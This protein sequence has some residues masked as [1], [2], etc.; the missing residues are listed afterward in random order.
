[1]D[2]AFGDGKGEILENRFVVDIDVKVFDFELIHEMD[3]FALKNR[4]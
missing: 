4:A 1:M 2:L 3:D